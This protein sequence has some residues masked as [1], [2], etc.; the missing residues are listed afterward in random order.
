[1]ESLLSLRLFGQHIAARSA[2]FLDVGTSVS[3][4]CL[5]VILALIIYNF[6]FN[7]ISPLK[8]EYLALI[9]RPTSELRSSE[10]EPYISG[11]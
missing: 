1:M 6:K 8:K 10:S 7:T 2:L 9:S 4:I 11:Y 5:I 3:R